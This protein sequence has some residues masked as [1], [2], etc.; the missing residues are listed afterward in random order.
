MNRADD[1]IAVLRAAALPERRSSMSRFGIPTERALGIAV[2]ALRKIARETGTDH[3]LAVAL[4]DTGWHEARLLAPMIADPRQTTVELAD[5]WTQQFDAW[6]VCDLCCQNLLRRTAFAYELVERYAPREE[7]YVRRTAFALTAAL[8]IGDKRSPDERF[9]PLLGLIGKAADDPRNF[10]KKAVN[11]AL[12]QIGKRSLRLHGE[13]VGLSRTRLTTI[14][15]PDDGTTP[16]VAIAQCDAP[17]L[18]AK[19]AMTRK[20]AEA[21]G[22]TLPKPYGDTAK[23][24]KVSRSRSRAHPRRARR[25]ARSSHRPG[26]GSRSSRATRPSKGFR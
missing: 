5:R 12:R 11:W 7:E 20:P 9:L 10:V 25:C 3:P 19:R 16:P 1:L 4:W 22:R 24:N 15:T 13:A 8:A 21:T 6:D 2:P 26:A 14:R 18:P 23:Q 17:L